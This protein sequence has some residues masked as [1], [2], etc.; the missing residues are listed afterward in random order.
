MRLV[1]AI[2]LLAVAFPLW[3]TETYSRWDVM[4]TLTAAAF[5]FCCWS[6]LFEAVKT[7]IFWAD[8]RA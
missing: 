5:I 6:I 8:E 3:V 1:F 2:F 7:I 4:D